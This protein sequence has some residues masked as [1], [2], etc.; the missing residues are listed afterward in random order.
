MSGMHLLSMSPI[1]DEA[2]CL[3][4]SY[5]YVLKKWTD[6]YCANDLKFCMLNGWQLAQYSIAEADV[7]IRGYR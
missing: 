1:V 7:N 2:D 6:I 3:M 4:P 5:K